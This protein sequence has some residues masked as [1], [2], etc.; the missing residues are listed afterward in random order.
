MGE[1][2]FQTS[3]RR[4]GL[5]RVAKVA[6]IDD[7]DEFDAA[8]ADA[9]RLVGAER[10]HALNE[11]DG[12]RSDAVTMGR[13]TWED[14]D[15]REH[16]VTMMFWTPAITAHIIAHE[17][18]HAAMLIY[19]IDSYRIYSRAASHLHVANEQIPYMVGDFF[20]GIASRVLAAGINLDTGRPGGRQP[21]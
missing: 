11:P 6:V 4:T 13:E 17:A 14:R 16:M 20:A 15:P 18:T 1:L 5:K 9:L 7:R 8:L 21:V 3:T 19:S 10:E 2:R 12:W